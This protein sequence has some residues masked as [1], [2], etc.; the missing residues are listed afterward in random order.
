MI[1]NNTMRRG[2][3]MVS[4]LTFAADLKILASRQIMNAVNYFTDGCITGLN[5]NKTESFK[6]EYC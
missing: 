5:A 2:V 6:D 3:T 4:A 1:A